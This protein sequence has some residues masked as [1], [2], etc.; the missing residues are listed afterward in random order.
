MTDLEQLSDVELGARLRVLAGRDL[1]PDA[2]DLLLE[3]AR[4]LA[5]T[6]A[7]RAS[8]ELLQEPAAVHIALLRGSIGR[9]SVR[10]LLHVYGERA[11]ARWERGRSVDDPLDW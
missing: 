3:A 9:P 10:S 11:L 5:E 7:L 8:L 6:Q 1:T 2:R 4:R